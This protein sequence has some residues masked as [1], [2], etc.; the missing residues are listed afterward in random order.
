M[1]K[2]VKPMASRLKEHFPMIRGRDYGISSEEFRILKRNSVKD[3]VGE[4]QK[5]IGNKSAIW[6]ICNDKLFI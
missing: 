5:E 3:M 6:D 4:E 2:G 1:E